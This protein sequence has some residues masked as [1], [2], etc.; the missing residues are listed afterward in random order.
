MQGIL[1]TLATAVIVAIVAAFAAPLVVDWN[2]WRATFESEASRTL[3]APVLIRG[4]IDADLLPVPRVVLRNVSVGADAISTGG[5]IAEVRADFSLGALMRGTFEAGTVRL[6]RPQLRVV[7]DSAGRVALP[8]GAGTPTGL[9]VSQLTV[10]DGSLDLLDRGADRTLRLTDVDVKGEA[11]SLTGPFRLEGEVETGGR[12]YGL[13]FNLGK[14][15]A[16]PARLRLI[17]DDRTR[18]LTLD[19]DG[20]FRLDQGTPRYDGRA[21]LARKPSAG[22]GDGWRL[23]GN[24]RAS[25]EALVAESLDLT[26]GDEARP[27]QLNGS[28]RLSLGRA[29]GLDAVLNART[30]DADLLMP[31]TGTASRSPAETVADL[32][33]AFG[34]LEP[35]DFP[36]RVG[37]GVDQLTVGGTVVRDARLDLSADGAAWRIDTAEAKLPGQTVVRLAGTP[38]AARAGSSFLGDLT[39]TSEDPVALLRWAAPRAPN[40][41]VAA[42]RGP[43]RLSGRINATETGASIANLSLMLG[44]SRAT[45]SAAYSI[46][47]PTR[48]DVA[49]ALDGFD[50]DP[51]LAATRLTL[52]SDIPFAGDIAITGRNLVLSGLPLGTLAV[53]ASGRDGA[54]TL[55][56]LQL[57][58]L[59]GLRL[60]G[61]GQF[62]R[63]VEPVA[64]R[65]D[66]SVSGAR[67]DGLVPVTR[68]VS[69]PEA[70][71]II[72]R[73]LPVAAPVKLNAYAEWADGGQRTL[74][75]E[76]QLGQVA[77]LLAVRRSAHG[78]PESADLSLT[79]TDGARVLDAIGLG[80]LKP[81]QGAGRLDLSVRGAETG[82]ST[83]E[84]RLALGEALLEGQGRL[85][86]DEADSLQP[87]LSLRLSN[88]DLSRIFAVAG[89]E[90]GPLPAALA[91]TLTRPEGRWQ[92]DGLTGTVAGAP[93]AGAVGIEPGPVPRLTGRLELDEVS[94]PRLIGVWGARS[95]GPDAGN[96]PWSAARFTQG[97]GPGLAADLELRAKRLAVSDS[98][99]LA[100][101]SLRVVSTGPSLEVRDLSG[102]LGGGQVSGTLTLRRRPDTVAADGHLT[103]DNV[104]SA[105]ILLPL[106]PQPRNPPGGKVSLVV[107]LLGTGR[108]PLQLVQSLVGQGTATLTDLEIPSADPTAI[109]AVLAATTMGPPPD[110]RRTAQFLDRAMA[111]GPLRLKSVET[112]LGVVNGVVRASPARTQAAGLRATLSGNLDLARLTLDATLD[113]ESLETAGAAPG[114]TI[115]WRG[116]LATPDRQ[117]TAAPLT[118]VIAMRA[119]E[120]ETKRLEE[121]Q[122]I[123]AEPPQQAAP[124]QV[125]AQTPPPAASPAIQSAPLRPIPQAAPA[126]PAPVV[127]AA[128]AVSAPVT[129]APSS[130]SPLSAPSAGVSTGDAPNGAPMQPS[131]P[132]PQ[133]APPTQANAPAGSSANAPAT[134]P[135]QSAP[136]Q[137]EGRSS[138][139]PLPPPVDIGP[140]SRSQPTRPSQSQSQTDTSRLPP[141]SGWGIIL[142]PPGLLPGE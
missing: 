57:D 65:V 48:L 19:L 127:P 59:A 133:P 11:R 49:L 23:A 84:G 24:L 139:P 14:A 9:A 33:G 61:K 6:V 115:T 55:S 74:R 30:L 52:A 141:P 28:A 69:G 92:L 142:R 123:G 58:D 138:A 100:E 120:R 2:A 83:L 75:A 93:V 117:V 54:W 71:D 50:L 60:D 66:V 27:V 116:P 98:Y 86:R 43:V 97:T 68:I 134:Q 95:V 56:R 34:A 37:I 45:G 89:T 118:A 4:K 42:L 106:S 124:S 29:M 99:R 72:Q 114:G 32:S 136:R 128:P 130:A 129:P 126:T 87:N 10:E 3:G 105:A 82:G 94:V 70:A 40:D 26:L 122:S 88:G 20:N 77:G 62:A 96:G 101:G 137:A 8:T 131:E 39:F 46:G 44:T 111:R 102:R 121:R 110:E 17:A 85:A 35:T 109:E 22:G 67:A 73:L 53:S 51:I 31:R 132:A 90:A 80:G 16:E 47:T 18:P 15:G 81:G 1:I 13:R 135:R 108:T 21:S 5:T 107:D 91:F 64:G 78:A 76:G 38:A 25:P 113:M 12:R 79:A 63:L 140:G 119:I 41:Y 112:T 103:L 7:M 104:D 125:P 36:V